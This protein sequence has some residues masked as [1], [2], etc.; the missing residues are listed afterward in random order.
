MLIGIG[1]FPENMLNLIENFDFISCADLISCGQY[2]I[3][4]G[5]RKFKV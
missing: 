2:S 5:G 4:A 3:K 1:I